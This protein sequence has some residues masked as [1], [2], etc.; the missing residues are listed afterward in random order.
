MTKPVNYP[1][2]PKY[3]WDI[4][5]QFT[6]TPRPSKNEQKIADY[7]L[8]IAKEKDLATKQDAAGNILV[9]VPVF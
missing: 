3:L 5:Y 4:F 8:N 6:Q 2:S 7:I 1:D 9:K